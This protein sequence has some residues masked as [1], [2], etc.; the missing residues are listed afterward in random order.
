[1]GNSKSNLI[2]VLGPTA[3]GKTD[4]GIYLAKRFSG[5]V[6]SADSMQV[7]RGM[8]I[9]SAAPDGSEMQ[10][11]KHHLIEFLNADEPFNVSDYVNLA[12]DTIK[13]IYLRN[14]VPF[15]VGGT[16]LYVNSL[17]ESI[18]FGDAVPDNEL[19]GKIEAEYDTLGGEKMLEKLSELDA[20]Y[21][22]TLHR[23][24]RKR[25]VRALEIIETTGQTV[26]K[27]LEE[28]KLG[29]KKYRV[30]YLGVA[31]SDREKL[32]DRINHRVD[33]MLKAGLEEE[34][35]EAYLSNRATSAQA[36]GHKE[37][38]DYFEGNKTLEEAV[39]F[40]K[41]QTRRYAKR[42]LTWFRRN[43]DINWLYRDNEDIYE[44][45]ERLVEEFLKEG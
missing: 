44:K 7:Y 10:G 39:D 37:L 36:I 32:Y 4:L 38:F 11:I 8:H 16:G 2:V 3:S 29:D 18:D 42:Q 43:P 1:M 28:S 12:D 40:L 14:N 27:R 21:A 17:T 19:R 34:A 24:D 15:I 31:F 30:L 26:T 20:D 23:N 5:E 35:R 45:A 25:I 13:G 9:A 22:K 41:M 33:M 6:V